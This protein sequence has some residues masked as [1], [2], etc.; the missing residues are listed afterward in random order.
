MDKTIL[1][2]DDEKAI[3]NSIRREFFDSP[4]EV[5][6]ATSGIEALSIISENKIDLIVTDMTM[7]KMDG[8]ELL[9]KVKELSPLTIRLILSGYTDEK[10]VFKSIYSNLAKLFITKPW[11]QDDF[12]KA[13]DDVFKTEDLL[14]NNISLTHIKEIGKLPTIP[15]LLKKVNEL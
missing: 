1:F 6:F 9:N 2:V 7:P 11:K 15:S 4:Y 8:Y 5:Y 3:L 14:S 13:I 10:I 12:R